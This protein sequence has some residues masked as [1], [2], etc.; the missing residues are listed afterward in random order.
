MLY[1]PKILVCTDFSTS[2]DRAILLAREVARKSGAEVFAFH[3]AE[4][5]AQFAWHSF[6]R[7]DVDLN[8]VRQTLHR[9]LT[10]ALE[11]Q[12]QRLDL[13][14]KVIVSVHEEPESA[15]FGVIDE[16]KINLVLVGDKGHSKF[17]QF[18]LGSFARKVAASVP[19]P[20][21]IVKEHGH[22][23]HTAAL[24]EGTPGAEG[25]IRETMELS[26]LMHSKLT[27]LSLVQNCPGFFQLEHSTAVLNAMQAQVDAYVKKL[28]D[29][30][31]HAVGKRE[32]QFIIKA[33]NECDVAH[34]LLEI[35]EEEKVGVAVLQRSNRSEINK[36]VI[37]STTN[38]ILERFKGHV[39]IF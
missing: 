1:Q 27:V 7:D 20:V 13:Q 29:R 33:S 39:L 11:L 37:G 22:F 12:L 23:G 25:T 30:F 9:D 3:H 5:T 14:A 34:H 15:L 10:E 16:H 17:H 21:L 26:F 6:G 32:A 4:L 38:K 18:L 36:F 19:V 24:V 2:S 28:V 35:L 31:Q 8:R